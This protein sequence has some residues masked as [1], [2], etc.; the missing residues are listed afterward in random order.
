[1]ANAFG[2]EPDKGPEGLER[3]LFCFA[4]EQEAKFFSQPGME[5][6]ITGIGRENAERKLHGALKNGGYQLVL[7][8]GFAGGLNPYLST[9]MVV[10]ASDEDAG[11]TPLLLAAGACPVKFHCTTRVAT[12][13]AEKKWLWEETGADAVEMES[14]IIRAICKAHGIPSATIRVISDAAHENLPLDFNALMS[15]DQK[16][17][18]GKLI[19][20]LL[21]SP[22]KIPALLRLQRQTQLAARNLANVLSK[23][24]PC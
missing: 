21:T 10:F 15:A 9:G 18:Y 8:C 6:L 22:G 11:L 17:N 14:Q 23:V 13:I 7:S 4:V 16:L 2:K 24:I 3:V 19:L 12:S 20:A 1:M 5:I